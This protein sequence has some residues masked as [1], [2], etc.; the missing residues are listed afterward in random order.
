MQEL[1]RYEASALFTPVEKLVLRYAD[2]MTKT[3]VSVPDSIFDELKAQ[4]SP[5]QLVE[6]T[7][8]IA[9]ENYRSRFNHAM[10]AEGEGFSDGSY[11]AIPVGAGAG[12][13]KG[14]QSAAV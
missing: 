9:W 12:H 6:L 5:A 10:G 11:C 4:F 13:Q 7:S 2:C 8:V 1:P 14:M 3:P